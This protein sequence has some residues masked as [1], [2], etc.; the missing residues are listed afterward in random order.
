MSVPLMQ[1]NDALEG[2][3]NQQ[4]LQWVSE[5]GGSS[6]FLES[7]FQGIRDAFLAERAQGASA[8]VQWRIEGPDGAFAYHLDITGG[9]C[10]VSAGEATAPDVTV[11][12]G[13]PDFLRLVLGNLDGRGAFQAGLLSVSGDGELADTVNSWFQRPN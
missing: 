9:R 1:H 4:I 8:T 12:V 7:V 11:T 3:S 5:A 13:L 2:Y 10:E 6:S